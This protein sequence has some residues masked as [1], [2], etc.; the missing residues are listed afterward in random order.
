[1]DI[2]RQAV[3]R[4]ADLVLFEE[5]ALNTLI[6]ASGGLMR[7]LIRMVRVAAEYAITEG[8]ERIADR[9]AK[10]AVREERG[11]FVAAL[12]PEDYPVLAARMQDKE[13][14]SSEA[15]QRLLQ[16]QALLEY[17][18]EGPWCDVNPVIEDLVRERV[19]RG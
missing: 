11:Y 4:C 18:A 5:E 16:A 14:S 3:E 9:H 15:V 10:A 7:A 2:L 13:L 8:E 6:R 12:A 17:D 19:G 1:M